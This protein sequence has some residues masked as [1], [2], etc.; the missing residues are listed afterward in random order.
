M[1]SCYPG[2]ISKV[3]SILKILFS[4]LLPIAIYGCSTKLPKQAI[5]VGSPLGLYKSNTTQN[6]WLAI[7]TEDNY[8][9]CSPK[10]CYRG[11]YQI[12]PANYGVILIDFYLSDIGL[13]IE[14]L[15]HGKGELQQFYDAMKRLRLK[16][17]R[18]NDLA[19]NIGDCRGIPCVGL[20]HTRAGVKFYK[21]KNFDAFW[22]TEE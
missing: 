5:T 19:F 7:M 20:G 6:F 11:K 21:I 17:P 3:K 2:E 13:A 8:W 10:D 22:S 14:R 18:A 12:V 1:A 16:M 15:S 4:L 9:L